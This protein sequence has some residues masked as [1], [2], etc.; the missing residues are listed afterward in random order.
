MKP[1]T[2]FGCNIEGDSGYEENLKDVDDS[3]ESFSEDSDNRGLEA[4]VVSMDPKPVG[5]GDAI[6]VR[7][8]QIEEKWNYWTQS[9]WSW[10]K[11]FYGHQYYEIVIRD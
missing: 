1:P 9:I 3:Q 5:K 2:P 4:E 10:V 8:I 7:N 6:S 11:T